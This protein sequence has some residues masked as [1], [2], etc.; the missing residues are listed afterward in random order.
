[1]MEQIPDGDPKILCIMKSERLFS[2]LK[3]CLSGSGVK[4]R[5]RTDSVKAAFESIVKSD[6][7]D[8]AM[9]DVKLGNASETAKQLWD[10]YGI[11]AIL[12]VDPDDED[13]RE[14]VN[15]QDNGIFLFSPF[16]A[17]TV[18]LCIQK[19]MRRASVNSD[20][21]KADSR[22]KE[23]NRRKDKNPVKSSVRS[24]FERPLLPKQEQYRQLIEGMNEGLA[25]LDSQG[26]ITFVNKRLCEMTGF[27]EQEMIGY[28]AMDFFYVADEK[29][30]LEQMEKRRTGQ[31][32]PYEIKMTTKSGEVIFTRIS[33][34]ILWDDNGGYAGSFGIVSD[35][36]DLKKTSEALKESEKRY[37]LLAD[38]SRDLIV[39]HSNDGLI[40]YVSPAVSDLLGYKPDEIVGKYITD[41]FFPEDVE[42]WKKNLS[43]VVAGTQSGAFEFRVHRKD[44]GFIWIET[45]GRPIIDRKTGKTN[46]LVAVSRDITRRKKI[47]E[48]LR[49]S[50]ERY[51]QL[52]DNAPAGIYVVDIPKMRFSSVNDVI[53]EYTGYSKQELLQMNPMDLLTEESKDAFIQ[54]QQEVL[55]GNHIQDTMEYGLK[56]KNGK[57]IWG[58]FNT[59]I[60]YEQEQPVRASVVAYDI[61]ERKIADKALKESEERYRFFFNNALIGLIRSRISDGTIIEANLR[62]AQIFGYEEIGRFIDEFVPSTH[63]I[64]PNAREHFL[65]TF[66]AREIVRNYEAKW[67]RSDG[68]T[69]WTRANATIYPNRNYIDFVIADI[70]EEKRAIEELKKAHD[71]LEEEVDKRTSRLRETNIALEVLLKKREYDKKNLEDNILFNIRQLIQPY[72]DKIKSSK[73]DNEQEAFLNILESNMHD[74]TSPFT[75]RLST[76]FLK[77]TP[78]ELQIANLIKQGRRTK[79]I[80]NILGLSS[81]TIETHRNNIRKKLGILNKKENLR[82]HLLSI[83]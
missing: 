30:W 22:P 74:I 11:P 60:F 49:E 34:K 7:P 76:T 47:E 39:L 65:N 31:E 57:S 61:T 46:G 24:T 80:A 1:M 5:E 2:E 77:F 67:T 62:A 16:H 36:T 4:I 59:R 79:E 70:S 17:G 44:K 75:S 41:F 29:H 14:F 56:T 18:S 6:F 66:G 43:G 28:A 32:K 8:L 13:A 64:D 82:T 15:I 71:A 54:R 68:R 19:A 58:L 42:E 83:Q 26:V 12:V 78:G 53:C 3:N 69:V 63:Y 25:I 35:I 33:P 48:K 21:E 55:G 37:R 72:I 51:R 45:I 10:R 52:V 81:R 9:V 50:E 73:L 40:R 38:Y 27:S 20:R 23:T